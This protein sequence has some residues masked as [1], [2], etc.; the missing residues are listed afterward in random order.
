MAFSPV[1]KTVEP[2]V[3]AKSLKFETS[4]IPYFAQKTWSDYGALPDIVQ[5]VLRGPIFKPAEVIQ[6]L[7]V[8]FNLVGT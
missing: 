7:F 3:K 2:I 1:L 4:V 8:C 6:M 5:S